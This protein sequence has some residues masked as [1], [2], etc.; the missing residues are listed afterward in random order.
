MWT[1]EYN[2]DEGPGGEG[3]WESWTVVKDGMGLD[4]YAFDC[5]SLESAEWLR[6]LLNKHARE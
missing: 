5:D 1:I 2:N 6:D 4:G 3:Y